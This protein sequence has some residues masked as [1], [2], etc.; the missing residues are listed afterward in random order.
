MKNILV[1][2]GTRP[3]AIKLAPVIHALR[4]RPRQFRCVVCTT[5]QHRE[6]LEPM[7]RFF[8]IR[9]EH[10]LD[11]MRPDQSLAGLTARLIEGLDPVL[12]KVRPDW[13]LVQGDT[14]TCVAASLAA[15]Y[16]RIRVGHVEAGLRTRDKFAPFPEEVN[17][18]VTGILADLHFAPTERAA[19]Q[20]RAEGVNPEAV[21]VTGNT[22]I[23]ALRW[24]EARLGARRPAG[25]QRLP[26]LQSGQR[27]VLV[28]G[29]RRENFGQGMENICL[30]LREIAQRH[31]EA[32]VVYPV[33]L[34]PN[35]RGPAGR[36]LGGCERVHLLEPVPYP[37]LVWLLRRAHLVL[38]DSGGIQ[39][40][41]PT[42][43]VPVLVMRDTTERPEGVEAG[44]ARLV[45]TDKARIVA[46][47]K[48]LLESKAAHRRMA[49][50]GNPYGDGK[51]AQRIVRRMAKE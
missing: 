21:L 19:A 48:E 23:D 36:V 43:G 10:R 31:P 18:R 30:A 6:M 14:T 37:A 32:V 9:P 47:V 13:L 46:A 35:V 7:L 8:R 41:A 5:G 25:L 17:R 12:E 22:V 11:V 2:F 40:E 38:T 34:N 45:G 4:E 26:P 20:L 29:H 24:A 1:V 51:A 49:R 28:T 33:H 15:Y 27:L 44:N 3:E 50:A 16:R 42:F 39:E